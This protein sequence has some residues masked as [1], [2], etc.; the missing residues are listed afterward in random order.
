MYTYPTNTRFTCTKCALCCQDTPNKTRH[1]LLLP[2]EAQTIAK[3]TSQ[4]TQAFT[5]K[6]Q[7]NQPYIYEMQKSPQGKCVFLKNNQCTIYAQRPLI[8]H[9]YPFE[10][11]TQNNQHIFD[12]TLECPA[13]N[14]GKPTTKKHFDDLFKLA[15]QKLKQP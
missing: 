1:I 14:Q 4:P 8:C 3:E 13:I 2:Q 12:F 5:T 9:F 10:L 11:K 7:N 15:Q 6:T